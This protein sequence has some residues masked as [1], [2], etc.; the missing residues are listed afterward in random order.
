MKSH[1]NVNHK[2]YNCLFSYFLELFFLAISAN[3]SSKVS[4]ALSNQFDAEKA[5]F[6]WTKAA[7]QKNA[8]ATVCASVQTSHDFLW[9][10]SVAATVIICTEPGNGKKV[11]DRSNIDPSTSELLNSHLTFG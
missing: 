7:Q 10:E 5:P 8:H 3:F 2:H 6:A 11:A 4:H 1:L 9:R